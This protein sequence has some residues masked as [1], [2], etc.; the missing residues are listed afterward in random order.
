M[1]LRNGKQL[2][3]PTDGGAKEQFI[4]KMMVIL[5]KCQPSINNSNVEKHHNM[6]ACFI[7]INRMPLDTW[8]TFDPT[9][10]FHATMYQKTME[11]TITIIDRSYMSNYTDEYK[12]VSI[13]LLSEMYKTRKTMANI[14]WQGRTNKNIQELMDAGHYHSE[15][16]YRC[17]KH[18]ISDKSESNYYEIYTYDDGEYSNVELYNWYLLPNIYGNRKSDKYINN[19]DHCFGDFIERFNVKMWN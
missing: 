14:L 17:W 11:C 15:Q 16:L 19:A 2:Q 3:T 9:L 12:S 8:T 18:I 1:Q 5:G 6:L 4:K 7:E 10:R 13:R